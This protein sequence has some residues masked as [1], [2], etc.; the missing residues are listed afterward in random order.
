MSSRGVD[1]SEPT[2]DEL[3]S[4]LL[5][6]LYY[7]MFRN[8]WMTVTKHFVTIMKFRNTDE[9]AHNVDIKITV[10]YVFRRKERENLSGKRNSHDNK[11]K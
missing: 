5:N 6:I 10:N 11:N 2:A 4:P 3:M 9:E 8:T 7:A 1:T